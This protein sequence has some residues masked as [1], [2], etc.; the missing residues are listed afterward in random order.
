MRRITIFILFFSIST[1]AQK[2]DFHIDSLP[3]EGVLLNKNW[4]YQTGD[5]PDWAKSDFDDSAWTPIDP[6]KELFALPQLF[7][8]QIKW[9]RLD[10]EVKKKLPNPLGIAVNQAGA[11]EIYLNGRLIHQFGHFDTDS[12]QVKAYDPLEIP[13]YFPADSVGHY[14]LAVRYALQPNI[15][16][17]NIYT[18]TKNRLFNATLF[19][20]VPTLN[21]QS[22]FKVYYLGLEIFIIGVFFMVFVLH[23]AF[24]FSQRSNTVHLLLAIFLLC[25]AFI[26]IFKIIG[27]NQYS[28]EERYFSLN[29]ASFFM[30]IV[31][32]CLWN[33][34]YRM[35][36]VRLDIYYY[37]L[38]IFTFFRVAVTGFT[39]GSALQSILM[40]VGTCFA[41]MILLRLT[42]ISLKKRIRGYWILGVAAILQMIGLACITVASLFWN[43]GLSPIGYKVLSNGISPYLID[44][45]FTLGS[46]ATP[47]GLSLFMGVQ[48]SDINKALTKQLVENDQLKNNAIEQEQE[49]QHLLA[50]QNET[51]E[52]QV[53]ERTAELNHSLETLIATQNQLIQ[54]E[55][56]ASLGELTAGIAH[57]IQNPLN[58]VTNFSELSVDLVKDLKDEMAKS[59]LTPEGG[60]IISPKDKEYFDELFTDLSQNQ[61][62][63]NHHGKRAS[64]I[65]K[66]MLEHSR[67]ST[68]VKEWVDINKLADEYLRLSYH[69]LRAKDKSFNVDF[70]TNFDVNL[71]KITI[72]PQDIGR[73]LLNLIN[74]AFYAVNKRKQNVGDVGVNYT[75]SVIISTQQTD[76]HIIIKIADNGTGMSESVKAKIFQ[77]FFTTKPTGQGTGLGLSLA[78]DIVTKGHGGT[79]E[80]ESTEGIG[81]TFTLTLPI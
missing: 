29:L 23:L 67:T 45:L 31:A 28:V 59:S 68:G 46:I 15:R 79:L 71:P 32:L 78:Y 64:S 8:A 21:A 43:Y 81:T 26:R 16:Y 10:F 74:N 54:S 25:N 35:A 48:S 39:Y 17:T 14:T 33:I 55:K 47:I 1:F 20:L 75:P 13:I 36:K 77:P 2:S 62:K 72:I 70:K 22:A 11:S 50:T 56:L 66:G 6:T 58:F 5:N 41:F 27:Q 9:L 38:I 65:V 76:N 63:I 40:L 24:Y 44:A 52:Q 3:T 73:V 4:T 19:N 69:G 37:A 80:V 42:A 53:T 34:Y 61:D 49:K 18:L 7:N 51:L 60:I 30:G 57:E 12:T